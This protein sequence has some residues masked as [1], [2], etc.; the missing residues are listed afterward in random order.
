M[1]IAKAS[2]ER[3]AA[4]I[5]MR[6]VPADQVPSVGWLGLPNLPIRTVLDIG[7]CRGG[8]AKEVL[9]P[10]FPKALIHSFEPSPDAFPSLKLTAEASD[11]RHF[12]HNFGFGEKDETLI[13]HSAVDALPSS[14]LLLS[15][16]EN[17]TAFP[18]TSKTKDVIVEVKVLD[19]IAPML[20]PAI[21]K[22]LLVKIDVQGFEDRVIRGGRTTIGHA[23]AVIVEV[24]SATLYEGQPTFREIFMEL[25]ALGF[26][27]IGVLDQFAKPDGTVL[28]YD[29]VF[30]KARDGS[31]A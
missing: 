11:G 12:A 30:T 2:A 28:Y 6:I 21:E 19:E 4:S 29:A 27:F 5:G 16:A 20:T 18:Q 17:T 23:R 3:A 25:D 26:G 9:A 10:R 13:L 1:P 22:D 31:S 24:Q 7:A 8:F 15:T 14:S